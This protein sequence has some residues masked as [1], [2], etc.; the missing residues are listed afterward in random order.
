MLDFYSHFLPWRLY[1]QI[2]A[3]TLKIRVY[4]GVKTTRIGGQALEIYHGRCQVGLDRNIGQT[5]P[6]AWLT[7]F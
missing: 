3:N 7:T 1:G 5:A 2:D 6:I 4:N